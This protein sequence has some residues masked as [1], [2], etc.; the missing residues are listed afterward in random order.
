MRDTA[1]RVV[2]DPQVQANTHVIGVESAAGT[3]HGRIVNAPSPNNPKTS[4]IVAY[5]VVSAIQRHFSPL[6]FA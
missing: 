6:Q 5:S 3:F 4:A 1:V 2:A